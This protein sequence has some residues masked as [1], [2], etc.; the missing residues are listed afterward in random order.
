[1]QCLLNQY[2]KVMHTPFS[3]KSATKLNNNHMR[4]LSYE[5]RGFTYEFVRIASLPASCEVHV[6]F[7]AN[8]R[9]LLQERVDSLNQRSHPQLSSFKIRGKVPNATLTNQG[10]YSFALVIPRVLISRFLVR[11]AFSV[12]VVV[13]PQS[14]TAVKVKAVNTH[15]RVGTD[16]QSRDNT[17]ESC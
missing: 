1:M 14:R 8:A 15:W 2:Y 7:H 9:T 5:I 10:N 16:V 17:H 13:S 6:L 11:S 12:I 4:K 3:S